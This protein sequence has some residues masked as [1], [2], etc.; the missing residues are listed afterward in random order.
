MACHNVLHITPMKDLEK[1]E[2]LKEEFKIE[3]DLGSIALD[4]IKACRIGLR[5]MRLAKEFIGID[6][7]L[8]KISTNKAHE[9][10]FSAILSLEAKRLAFKE[11]AIKCLDKVQ[12]H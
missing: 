6:E 3:N 10:F 5:K 11:E 8:I 2:M 7:K 4:P 12:I 9:D 1:Y